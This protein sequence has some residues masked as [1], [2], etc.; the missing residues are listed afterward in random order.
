MKTNKQTN[1][2]QK[3]KKGNATAG[4]LSRDIELVPLSEQLMKFV[5]NQN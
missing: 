4:R 5:R 1:K 3:K 2:Q